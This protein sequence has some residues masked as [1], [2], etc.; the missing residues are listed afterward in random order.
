MPKRAHY[1][2]HA[3]AETKNSRNA[4][5]GTN[6]AHGVRTIPELFVLNLCTALINKK[7]CQIGKNAKN[8]LPSCEVK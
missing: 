2:L 6:I 5:I 1:S 3:T 4:K 8:V 7:N